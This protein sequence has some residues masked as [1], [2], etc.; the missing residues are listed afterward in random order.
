MGAWAK[1]LWD[2]D[3]RVIILSDYGDWTYYWGCRGKGV[4]VAQFLS[5]LDEQYM[6]KKM[7][8]ADYWVPDDDATAGYIRSQILD[9]RRR[10]SLGKD[11][12]RSEW[13]TVQRYDDGDIGF[14]QWGNE[15]DFFSDDW[16]EYRQTTGDSCWNNFWEKLWVL[17]VPEL[18]KIATPE[19]GQKYESAIMKLLSE[20]HESWMDDDDKLEFNRAMLDHW[21]GIKHIS[22][23]IHAGVLSGHSV[24][25]QMEVASMLWVKQGNLK[26]KVEP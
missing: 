9:Q 3:G 17:I 24:E 10:A 2:D 1:L 15:T 5:K 16:Y 20:M 19:A 18:K 4:S 13:E 11:L 8:G 25:R 22:D 23:K 6:G 7:L 14:E 12:A 26:G 21:G